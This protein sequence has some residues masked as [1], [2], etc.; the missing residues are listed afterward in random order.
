M[1]A[2]PYGFGTLFFFQ[3]GDMWSSEM[4]REK[5]PHFAVQTHCFTPVYT[6]SELWI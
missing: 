2:A 1:F 4:A 3:C 5:L 6:V